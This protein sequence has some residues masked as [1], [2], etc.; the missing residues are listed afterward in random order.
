MKILSE[1]WCL[2]SNPYYINTYFLPQVAGLPTNINFLQ[3]LASH[4]AFEGGKVET[5]FIEHFKDDLFVDPNN[6]VLAKEA[7]DAA[8]F[9][10]TL[11]AAC[12]IEKEHSTQ[13]ENLPGRLN[14]KF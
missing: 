3:K 6:S 2:P 8:R 12:I 13:K 1:P 11:V 4:W 10:A 9:S 7:H 5:H 14:L